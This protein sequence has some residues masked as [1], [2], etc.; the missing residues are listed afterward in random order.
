MDRNGFAV[1]KSFQRFREVVTY[2][3]GGDALEQEGAF[4]VFLQ[5][6]L[7]LP[8]R[9]FRQLVMVGK[10]GSDVVLIRYIPKTPSGQVVE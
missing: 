5:S 1:L 6:L 4:E 10:A 3:G 8:K 9:R 2:V 7:A